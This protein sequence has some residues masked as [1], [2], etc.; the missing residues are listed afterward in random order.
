MKLPIFIV[1]AFA[2]GPFAGNPAA[3]V[4]TEE[5][6]TESLMQNIAAQNNLSETAFVTLG[7]QPLALRWFTPTVEV[8]LCGHATLAAAHVLLE[9]D[10]IQ[11]ERVTFSS[12]SGE[13]IVRKID[14]GLQ[15]D[16]PLRP[17]IPTTTPIIDDI[18]RALHC[19]PDDIECCFK[20]KALMVVLKD[21][22]LLADL[23]PSIQRL[24]PLDEFAVMVTA[25][26]TQV[27]FV[28]RMF[29]PNAGIDE[30][31][32]TGSAYTT[33]APYWGHRFAKTHLTAQQ[34]SPRGG[35]ITCDIEGDRVL[36]AGEVR[37]YLVGEISVP[38]F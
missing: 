11:G 10:Y 6:L 30:D 26:S 38:F 31:P 12:L 37:E 25:A 29:A 23:Q 18:A 33:L 15:L 14:L 35:C 4:V 13:L 24:K 19:Q 34:L 7:E 21:E 8:D 22:A 28:M 5:P 36:I 16:F 9:H 3:V 2:S 32:V 1:N 20:A 27:D 17:A